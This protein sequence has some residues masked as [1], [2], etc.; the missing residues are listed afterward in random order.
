MWR[1]WPLRCPDDSYLTFLDM[2]ALDLV[3]PKRVR[4]VPML[5]LGAADDAMFSPREVRRTGAACGA[6]TEVIADLAHDM[7]LDTRWEVVAHQIARWLG[8][9]F[10][11]PL[12]QVLVPVNSD[13]GRVRGGSARARVQR[14]AWSPSTPTPEG[15]HVAVDQDRMRRRL[16]MLLGIPATQGNAVKVLRNGDQIFPAMLDAIRSAEHTV[17]LLTYVYWQGWPAQA[18][19]Q[20]LAER[21]AAGCRVRVLIDAVGGA[22]MSPALRSEMTSAGADVRLFR[23]PWLRSPFTHNHRTHRKVLVVD[24]E[25]AFTGGVGIASEWEGDARDPSQWRDTQIHLRGPAVAGLYAAFVQNWSETGGSLDDPRDRYPRLTS[26][27][28]DL[29]QVVRGTATLGW[30]DIQTAWF[31]LLTAAEERITLQS[32]YFAPDDAFLDLLLEAAGRG[33]RVQVLLPGPHY[34]KSVSRLTSERYYETL[35]AN[36]V[37]V[38]RFQP[39]MLHTKVLSIDD[40]VAMIGSA[41][42]NRRSMDHDEEVVCILIGGRSP[43]ELVED[44]ER[45]LE[46]AERVEL[47]RWRDRDLRQRL[48]EQAV[49]PIERF[50]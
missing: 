12:G 16:E 32:A 5:V 42:A 36:G 27:G 17:D 47:A 28:T 45:D 7:M 13:G 49:R 2:L 34:D 29:V 37:E 40:C 21:A 48:G 8:D 20:A 10:P 11:N 15:P 18:F 44:F 39:T 6:E 31:A 19:A 14:E 24:G 3:R 33:V 23:P 41:N 9:R 50:V 30:D 22:R 46:R 26:G 38:W 4:R 1:R 43:Q 25:Q 35:L